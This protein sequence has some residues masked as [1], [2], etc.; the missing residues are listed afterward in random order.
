VSNDPGSPTPGTVIAAVT[1]TW[2]CLVMTAIASLALFAFTLWLADLLRPAF[3]LDADPRWYLAGAELVLVTWLVVAG[4]F[5]RGVLRRRQRARVGL[6]FSSAA[7][8]LVSLVLL[9]GFQ[10]PVS[11]GTLAG[12]IAV[13]VLLFVPSSNAWFRQDGSA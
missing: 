12:A 10:T 13:L 3:D 4:A 6:A 8:V 1:V 11:L 2:T 5:A 9:V 7:T